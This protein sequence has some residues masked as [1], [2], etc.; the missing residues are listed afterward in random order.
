MTLTTLQARLRVIVFA[1]LSVSL[2][3]CEA[4]KE[5]P[6]LRDEVTPPQRHAAS[7][8]QD[9]LLG[10]LRPSKSLVY[11]ALC[12]GKE[13]G[14]GPIPVPAPGDVPLL[15][16][17][18]GDGVSTIGFFRPDD[19]TFRLRDTSSGGDP[20]DVIQLGGPGDIPVVGDWD[21]DGKTNAPCHRRGA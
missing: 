15:G 13:G 3:A 18:N 2:C 6:T 8:K 20:D 10:L 1:T 11:L 7:L 5:A 9:C 12:S 17:W 14:I 19:Q 16:D 21:G 4:E